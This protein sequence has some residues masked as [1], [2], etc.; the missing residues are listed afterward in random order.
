M[1]RHP[2]V[3]RYAVEAESEIESERASE[4]ER[5]EMI[6]GRKRIGG[7]WALA[8]IAVMLVAASFPAG[9]AA[10]D[11]SQAI[12]G[13]I[14]LDP[15]NVKDVLNGMK[16]TI[17]EFYAPWCGHCKRLTPEYTKLARGDDPERSYDRKFRPGGEGRLRQ[18]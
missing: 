18:A 3:L 6:S 4:S 10:Q 12:P 7:A 14:D 5:E 8:S 2:G 17:A 16:I 15:S 9:V 1:G 11:P 13:V